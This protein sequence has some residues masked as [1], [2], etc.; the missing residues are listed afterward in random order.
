M[1][2]IMVSPEMAILR[3]FRKDEDRKPRRDELKTLLPKGNLKKE[4]RNA[5]SNPGKLRRLPL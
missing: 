3:I 1:R 4:T 2:W 5:K